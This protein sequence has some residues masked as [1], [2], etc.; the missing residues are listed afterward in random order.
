M[1]DYAQA[2]LRLYTDAETLYKASPKRLATACHLYGLAAEC[3]IKA[4]IERQPGCS[5]VPFKHL[6]ELID[7]AKRLLNGRAASH[8][9]H[10]I[11]SANFMAGWQVANR[12]WADSSFSD[13]HTNKIKAD[14]FKVVKC[15]S[16]V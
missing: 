10:N 8:L 1:E 12:Y 14:S 6:P 11:S 4:F 7:D 15:I 5:S 2:S 13:L 9:L 3:A 16:E